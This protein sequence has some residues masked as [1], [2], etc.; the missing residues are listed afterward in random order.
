MPDRYLELICLIARLNGRLQQ[1]AKREL[2]DLGLQE[3]SSLQGT[4]L[5]NMGRAALPV[6]ILAQNGYYLGNHIFYTIK[7]MVSN[8]Y[9]EEA[10]LPADRRQKYVRISKKGLSLQERLTRL[11]LTFFH[12]TDHLESDRD[13]EQVIVLLREL[14]RATFSTAQHKS[15]VAKIPARRTSV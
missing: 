11:Y 15:V 13:M 5:L 9:L 14:E 12:M 8:G 4:M 1:V 3:I 2:D 7:K 10:C 6:R